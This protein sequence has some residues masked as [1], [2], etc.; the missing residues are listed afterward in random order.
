MITTRDV[1][2]ITCCILG[3][4]A[5][6]YASAAELNFNYTLPTS[7]VDGAK[8]TASQIKTCTLYRNAQAA[9]D[10]GKSGAYKYN[11][12]SNQTVTYSATCTD[13][14]GVESAKSTTITLSFSP[15]LAP[16]LEIAP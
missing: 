9:G 2:F 5:A 3:V 12:T 8:L 6:S 14:N 11:E 7:R 13:T 10:M 1:V 16:I 4:I 15:P